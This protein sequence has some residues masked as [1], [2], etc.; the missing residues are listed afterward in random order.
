[1]RTSKHGESSPSVER[2]ETSTLGASELH[3]DGTVVDILDCAALDID[4][5]RLQT[6][7]RRLEHMREQ[8]LLES[9]RRS[10]LRSLKLL[11]AWQTKRR[12]TSAC[13]SFRPPLNLPMGVRS[14]VTICVEDL[15]ASVGLLY[16]L[17]EGRDARRHHPDASSTRQR[18]LGAA[19]RGAYCLLM[20]MSAGYEALEVS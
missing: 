19:G 3:E 7:P 5:L 17:Q 9:R 11:V 18:G 6:F 4:S 15:L 1:M 12:R 13:M 8:F 2:R 10:A 14:D 20:C 16:A